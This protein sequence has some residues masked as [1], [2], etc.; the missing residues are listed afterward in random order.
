MPLI[1]LW[2]S[3][4]DAVSE[5]T[6]EQLIS[7]AGSGLLKDDTECAFELREYL[8]CAAFERIS[9]YAR[10]CLTNSF[11]NSGFVLQDLVNEMGRRLGYEVTSGKYH[12]RKGSIGFDGIWK[13]PDGHTIV[14]EVKTSDAYRISLDSIA[15]YRQRL[16]EAGEIELPCSILVI[17][18]RQD[19]GEL[20]AQVRGSRHAWD[21]R[22]V[23]VDALSRL[24]YLNFFKE[25][26]PGVKI[27]RVLVPWDYTKL[28]E[29][30][31]LMSATV[32]NTRERR[33]RAE[34]AGG[35][36]PPDRRCPRDTPGPAVA[37]ASYI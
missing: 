7:V 2:R 26:R 15:S 16:L 13:S 35:R 21:I 12:G 31:E 32:L 3:N 27:R 37:E 5:L 28:D 25:F 19:T 18:G 11:T 8:R 17:V 1:S 22:L 34:I 33:R 30:V 14:A 6:I 4:P 36:T 24:V 29:I 9:T 23:S 10:Y 20:E